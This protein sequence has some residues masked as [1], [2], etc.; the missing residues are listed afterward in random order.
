MQIL[1]AEAGRSM[2]VAHLSNSD[3]RGRRITLRAEPEVG[4][5]AQALEVLDEPHHLAA[6]EVEKGRSSLTY[7][8]KLDSADL[9]APARARTLTQRFGNG[10]GASPTD[11]TL[12][13]CGTRGGR[14]IGSARP[15]EA[16]SL[17]GYA[18]TLC[19]GEEEQIMRQRKPHPPI[20]EDQ[21]LA[22]ARPLGS[23]QEVKP[24]EDQVSSLIGEAVQAVRSDSPPK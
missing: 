8:R 13:L 9:A 5:G 6:A 3:L 19:C 18:R 1:G 10:E 22:N 14:V 12:I 4:K 21:A 23:V 11:L 7:V 17:P 20:S 24:V 15:H 16:S 2:L